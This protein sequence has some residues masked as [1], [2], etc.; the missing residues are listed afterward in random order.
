MI[1]KKYRIT[2]SRV[3]ANGHG[4]V[5]D[6]DIEATSEEDARKKFME[7]FPSCKINRVI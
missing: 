1:L 2:W 6:Y 3:G 4:H 7:K 5:G